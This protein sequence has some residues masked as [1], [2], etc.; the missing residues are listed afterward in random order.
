VQCRHIYLAKSVVINAHRGRVRLVIQKG[1]PQITTGLVVR[2]R[3]PDSLQCE[4]ER[5]AV[6]DGPVGELRQSASGTL[7]LWPGTAAPVVARL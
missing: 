6:N 1:V 5:Q 7:P 3:P 4:L 2:P